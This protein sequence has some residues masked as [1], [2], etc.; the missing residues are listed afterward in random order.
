[1]FLFNTKLGNANEFASL[2]CLYFSFTLSILNHFPSFSEVPKL[3]VSYPHPISSQMDILKDI[4]NKRLKPRH[5]EDFVDRANYATM[6]FV[7]SAMALLCFAKANFHQ[8]KYFQIHF[9]IPL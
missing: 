1:V 8:I 4:A 7:L 6:P 3:T 5:E 9:S 2:I